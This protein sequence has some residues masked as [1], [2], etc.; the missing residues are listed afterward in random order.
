LNTL[1]VIAN[2]QK[3]GTVERRNN[4]LVFRY[5]SKWQSSGGAF[6][7]S[8]SMPLVQ[9][10]HPHSKIEPYLWNLLPDNGTVL[11][12]W[13]KRFH[14]SH[15]NVFS[16]LEH[17]GEDCAG[18]IQFIPEAREAE[19]LDQNHE[20]EVEWIADA[21]LAKRIETLLTD[22]GAQ[23]TGTDAGQFS[24]AGAQPKT[25]LYQSPQTGKWGIP[26]GQTP[27]THILKP[28]SKDF[29]GYAENEHFCLT[30]ISQLGIKSANSSVLH[31]GDV[32]VI[33]VKRYDRI[34]KGERC[35]RIHQEDFCQ[36]RALPPSKKYQ[37][38]GGPSVQDVA[39]TIWDISSKARDDIETFAKALIVNFLISG[40]DAHAKNYSLLIA[41]NNQVRLAPLYD[42]ASTLPYPKKVSPHKAKLAMKIGS[43]YRVKEI[44]ARHWQQC[45]KQLRLKTNG[46]MA[47]FEAL[48]KQLAQACAAT[49]AELQSQGLTHEVIEAL[50][51]SI[52]ERSEAVIKQYFPPYNP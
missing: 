48:A 17:V 13:G 18:A 2:Q 11:E 20:E 36:A 22:H 51:Q 50:A 40:T 23:R 6:P 12:E 37:N 29:P 30:L 45:A 44:E 27:T 4:R 7:L 41:G 1:S 19:L 35:L 8:A 31:C 47:M 14:V 24:L 52:T 38:E 3:M 43:K 32:P 46:F 39:N 28:A 16:L 42:I 25:A 9:G 15:N 34:F 5:A 10:E 33:C 21:D 26:G 49:S